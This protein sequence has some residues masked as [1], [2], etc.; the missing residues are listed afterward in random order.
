MASPV[1]TQQATGPRIWDGHVANVAELERTLR[2]LQPAGPDGTP[3]ASATVLNLVVN[4]D[5][6]RAPAAERLISSLADHQPSRAIIVERDPDG[7]GIDAH[8]EARAQLVGSARAPSRV[9]LLHLRLH[10]T[11]AAGA[12]SAV[13]ALLRSDLPVYLWCPGAPDP[14]DPV[15]ADLALHADR[16]IVEADD[17]DG[18]AAVMLLARLINETGP[19]VTDLAWAALTPWRQ[20]LNQLVPHEHLDH[21]RRGARVSIRHTS[22]APGLGALLLAGW[23]RDSV[24]DALEIEFST[25]A[26]PGSPDI[27]EIRFEVPGGRQLEIARVSGRP[28]ASVL[29]RAP[30]ETTHDRMMPMPR[31]DR[32]Q[33]LAGELELQRRDRPFERS[34]RHAQRIAR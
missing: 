31:P 32:T 18:A 5:A 33:L 1:S 14:A 16:L 27:C 15:F 13:R 6:S 34:L 17:G 23:L 3:L 25:S 9:E 29:V 24:G 28:A 20:L 26:R 7:D 2:G 22:P 21:M 4:T 30:H 12:A 8:V 10:G 11:A 19:A